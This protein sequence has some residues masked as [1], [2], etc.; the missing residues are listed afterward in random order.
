MA[1][2]VTSCSVH[3]DLPG[4]KTKRVPVALDVPDQDHAVTPPFSVLLLHGAGGD[5]S[6]RNLPAFSSAVADCG[7]PCARFTCRGPLQH[8]VKVAA[9]LLH[10]LQ[11]GSVA[12]EL[13]S[14]RH[15]VLAGHSMGGRVCAELAGTFSSD[16]LAC[17]FLSYPLHPV[18]HPDTL[19]VE[20][21]IP[22]KCPLLFIRGTKDP[23]SQQDRWD[24][25]L[26]RL[27]SNK[28]SVHSVDGGGHMLSDL[29][30]AE[31]RQVAIDGAVAALKAFLNSLEEATGPESGGKGVRKAAKRKKEGHDDRSSKRGAGPPKKR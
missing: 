14:Q 12:P 18:D 9:A 6:S 2:K 11:Q 20:S 22:L 21:L 23:F 25:M 31:A 8:R 30:P 4:G 17:V 7:F 24:E 10:S 1:T 3:L 16:I 29:V 13:A 27:Q 5:L 15:W 19:R 26:G 28:V